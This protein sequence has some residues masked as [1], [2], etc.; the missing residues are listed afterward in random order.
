MERS[1]RQGYIEGVEDK[2][3]LASIDKLQK[4]V[5]R[6]VAKAHYLDHTLPLF[7][8]L[9][10]LKIS[11]LSELLLL[12]Q[13]HMYN[14]KCVPVP[15]SDLFS[16]NEQIHQ[17]NTSRRSNPRVHKCKTAIAKKGFV[18]VS[19]HIWSTI[20]RDLQTIQETKTFLKKYKTYLLAKYI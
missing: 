2:G 12:K 20:N 14:K 7:K 10:I 1:C 15:I 18:Y 8:K 16:R 19:T 5:V 4:K 17:Y 11:D 13:M 6:C 3:I 9:D